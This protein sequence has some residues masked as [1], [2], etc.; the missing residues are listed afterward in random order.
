[1][2]LIN[3]ALDCGLFVWLVGVDFWGSMVVE[4]VNIVSQ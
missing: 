3:L 4:E 2:F 1:L